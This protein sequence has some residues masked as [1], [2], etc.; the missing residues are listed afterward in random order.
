M[1]TTIKEFRDNMSVLQTKVEGKLQR[2][3]LERVDFIKRNNH[4]LR[5]LLNLAAYRLLVYKKHSANYVNPQTLKRF[6]VENTRLSHKNMTLAVEAVRA[7]YLTS[8]RTN[9]LFKLKSNLE[10]K[11]IETPYWYIIIAEV[12]YIHRITRLN[13]FKG[14]EEDEC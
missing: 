9:Q 11:T 10:L 12:R 5:D 8:L 6:A 3:E 13:C 7:I 4:N 2:V 14:A 1:E